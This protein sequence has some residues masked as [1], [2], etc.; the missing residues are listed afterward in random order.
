MMQL[1]RA[2][3]HHNSVCSIIPYRA[4]SILGTAEEAGA[5]LHAWWFQNHTMH[6]TLAHGRPALGAS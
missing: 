4:L 3:V 2:V 6:G 1:L 5:A